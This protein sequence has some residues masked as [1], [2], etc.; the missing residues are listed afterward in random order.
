MFSMER[1]TA[2]QSE[3]LQF[4][5]KYRRKEGISP[6]YREIAGRFGF[7]STKAVTDHVIALEKKGYVRRHGGRSRCIEL[8]CSKGPSTEPVSVPVL[9]LIPAGFPEEQTE[10]LQGT[11]SVDRKLLGS[12]ADHRL[13]ALEV[14][15]DSMDGRGI[16]E[17]DW[18]VADKDSQ[19]RKGDVVVAL[20]DGQNTLK[21]LAGRKN[22]YYLKAEN[23]RH[24][25]RIPVEELTI[26]GVVRV[27]IRRMY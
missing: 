20:I 19:P 24:S 3:I 10:Q 4:I 23:P 6:A 5:R 9:G 8:L 18:I 26:Q 25:D 15:G 16:L 1:L 21:T 12:F 13:F 22:R 14:N 27:V 2:R 7:K 11:I 17:G